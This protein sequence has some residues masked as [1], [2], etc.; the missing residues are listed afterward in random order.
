MDAARE[1][2]VGAHG[3]ILLPRDCDRA[4]AKI[5][6]SFASDRFFSPQFDRARFS[7]WIGLLSATDRQKPFTQS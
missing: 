2:S 4:S 1:F 7:E 5:E 6:M 3:N